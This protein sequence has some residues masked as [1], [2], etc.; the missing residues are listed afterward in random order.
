MGSKRG[1]SRLTPY[2]P[3]EFLESEEERILFMEEIMND[4]DDA[5]TEYGLTV[6]ARSRKIH[7][8]K[9][10]GVILRIGLIEARKARTLTCSLMLVGGIGENDLTN[11]KER[12]IG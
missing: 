4:N 11:C 7:G 2:D 8:K 10:I 1:K 3:A 12:P 6:V 5:L 9:G